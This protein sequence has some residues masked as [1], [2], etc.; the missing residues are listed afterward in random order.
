M[1][2]NQY[3]PEF[4]VYNNFGIRPTEACF[5]LDC[6]TLKEIVGKIAS[7]AISGVEDVTMQHDKNGNVAMFV[8][9][10][11]NSDHFNDSR[12]MDTAIR[13]KLS[14]LSGEMQA[15]IEKFGWNEA[16]DDP[17]NG[18]TK[19]HANKIIQNNDNAEIKGKWI[20]VHVA[21]NPFIFIMFDQQGNGY[22]KDFNRN[23]P[24]T[25]LSREWVWEKNSDGKRTHLTGIKI[26]KMIHNPSLNRTALHVGGKFN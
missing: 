9:F 2:E 6:K 23:A 1:S 17:R 22:K 14:R 21:I 26:R 19:V 3:I 20:A 18:N 10:S 7:Q 11:A 5:Q 25:R 15:F 13:S 24:K 4:L 8:W 12:T 16:D